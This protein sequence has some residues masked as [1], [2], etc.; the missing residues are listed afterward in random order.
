MGTLGTSRPTWGPTGAGLTG[1]HTPSAPAS[2]QRQGEWRE[3]VRVSGGRVR[4]SG[5]R[6][7]VSGERGEGEWREG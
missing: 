6:V 5:G 7:R 2:V 4:V 3:G 1:S